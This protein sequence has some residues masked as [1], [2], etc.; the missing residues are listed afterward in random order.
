MQI[1]WGTKQDTEVESDLGAVIQNSNSQVDIEVVDA[2]AVDDIYKEALENIKYKR[3]STKPNA[4][5]SVAE[6]EQAAKDYYANVRTNLLLAWVLSNAILLLAILGGGDAVN[7]FTSDN[8]FS[9]TKAY[10]T[11]ILAFV[12]VTTIVVSQHLSLSEG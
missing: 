12:A 7:T 2:A 8:A 11:F 9:R 1:S 3:P 6:Q 10:M 4:G 5:N